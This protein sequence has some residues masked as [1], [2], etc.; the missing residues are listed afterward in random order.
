M[1]QGLGFG[2]DVKWQDDMYMLNVSHAC[3]MPRPFNE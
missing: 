1:V 2:P 3:C